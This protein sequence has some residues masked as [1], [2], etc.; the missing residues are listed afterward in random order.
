MSLRGRGLKKD[1][2]LPLDHWRRLSASFE[3][4]FFRPIHAK[5]ECK[6]ALWRRKPI[7]HPV[8]CPWLMFEIKIH[9]TIGIKME[10]VPF[11][12]CVAVE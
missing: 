4:C 3:H 2:L 11:T 8:P 1:L 6:V 9:R 7:R 5:G 10:L 12:Q